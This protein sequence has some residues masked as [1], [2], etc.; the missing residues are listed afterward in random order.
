MFWQGVPS[1]P[2]ETVPFRQTQRQKHKKGGREKTFSIILHP[3]TPRLWRT[4]ILH[5]SYIDVVTPA[6]SWRSPA[7]IFRP[8]VFTVVFSL[9]SHI[10]STEILYR[11]V[12]R[13]QLIKKSIFFC[14]KRLT[15]KRKLLGFIC[16][17]F[18]ISF[19]VLNKAEKP[20]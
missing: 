14:L 10:R 12:G 4:L 20:K 15:E 7:T 1:Q 19:K 8:V 18:F 17:I 6:P 9:E 16:F 5:F 3:T 2:W 11:Q 13:N